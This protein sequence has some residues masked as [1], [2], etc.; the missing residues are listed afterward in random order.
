MLYKNYSI[1]LWK[2]EWVGRIIDGVNYSLTIYSFVGKDEAVK[3]NKYIALI[4]E[5]NPFR[6][7]AIYG[8]ST[9][10]IALDLAKFSIDLLESNRQR[11]DMMERFRI[12]NQECLRQRL[13]KRLSVI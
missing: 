7:V 3:D 12:Y 11:F 9:P 10:L 13:E 4:C 2:S 8:A 6:S 5:I 1:K